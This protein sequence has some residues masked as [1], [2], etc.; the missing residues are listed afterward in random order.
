MLASDCY[1]FSGTYLGIYRLKAATF[2]VAPFPPTSIEIHLTGKSRKKFKLS[3]LIYLILDEF[4]FDT[5]S[6]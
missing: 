5:E 1:F 6:L 4:R 2:V 3:K